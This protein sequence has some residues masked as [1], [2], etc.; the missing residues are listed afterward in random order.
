MAMKNLKDLIVHELKDLLSAERQLTRALPKLAKAASNEEL[1]EA[2]ESH[3]EETKN[4]VERIEQG[5]KQLGETVRAEKCDGM[6]GLIE[7]GEDILEKKMPEDVKDVML[8]AAAQKAEHYE[9]ASYG[10][11]ISWAEAADVEFDI[12]P[13]KE[14]LNE[15][16]EADEKLT[17]I[18]ERINKQAVEAA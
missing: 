1:R 7:E 11:L 8:I 13:F 16:K 9:M 5:L 10:T 17:Q 12:D 4:H 3:L 18:A 14:T 2:F 15:E 6:A